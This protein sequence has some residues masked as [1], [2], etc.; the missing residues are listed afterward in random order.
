MLSYNEGPAI[1]VRYALQAQTNKTQH[2]TKTVPLTTAAHS[3][4]SFSFIIVFIVSIF[5]HTALLLI[6]YDRQ[7][8]G[9]SCAHWRRLFLGLSEYER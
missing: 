8:F 5:A 3:V 4:R 7:T 6:Q 1:L 9:C 2:P